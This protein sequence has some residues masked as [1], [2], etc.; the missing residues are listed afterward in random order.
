MKTGMWMGTGTVSG[1]GTGQ[2]CLLLCLTE[3]E[4]LR[5]GYQALTGERRQQRR[6]LA[7]QCG[8]RRIWGTHPPKRPADP[9]GRPCSR[10]QAGAGTHQVRI[11]LLFGGVRVAPGRLGAEELQLH[12]LQ[13][14]Q[15]LRDLQRDVLHLGARGGSAPA[16]RPAA[17]RCRGPTWLRLFS[18]S[19]CR[20]SVSLR[21]SSQCCCSCCRL[22][23]SPSTLS[24]RLESSS[25]CPASVTDC[26]VR[27]WDITSVR[28]TW[29]WSGGVTAGTGAPTPRK[30]PRPETPLL[31]A[32]PLP[33]QLWGLGASHGARTAPMGASK[34]VPV[35]SISAGCG[36]GPRH[37]ICRFVAGT[38]AEGTGTPCTAP[39]A[40][41]QPG[42]RSLAGVRHVRSVS[43][44]GAVAR[45]G[46]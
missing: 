40:R 30:A 17:P 32:A 45:G 5:E 23:C 27:A 44:H 29:G 6:I 21:T 22:R 46:H 15:Q 1:Q 10:A 25:P 26:T 37:G 16:P 3:P 7:Q 9:R 35:L 39:P 36:A 18:S 11:E 13:P 12:L 8:E 24:P 42:P 41:G 38:G 31:P 2:G 34:L 28:S 20:L 14:L 4:Q 33:P 43:G 19:S